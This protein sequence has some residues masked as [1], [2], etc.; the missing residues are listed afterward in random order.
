[1]STSWTS[2]PDPA[3]C[4][5]GAKA[6][7]PHLAQRKVDDAGWCRDCHYARKRRRRAQGRRSAVRRGYGLT[8]ADLVAL[9]GAQRGKD[10][11]VHCRCGRVVGVTKEPNV[12][13]WHG[14][15]HCSGKG[16]RR[17]VRGLLCGPC[18]TFLG[19][20]GD[21]PAALYALAWHVVARPAQW[22]LT[23]VP[24]MDEDG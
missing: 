5:G 9:R 13:H 21:D 19:Y 17:C 16:C 3:V 24:T 18:N 20:I 7:P 8:D 22:V 6:E 12:D 14:C 11:K 4:K 15:P 10:G 2:V 1:M 23:T